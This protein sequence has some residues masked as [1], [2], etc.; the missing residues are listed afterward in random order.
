MDRDLQLR[1]SLL[2][3]D[4][5]LLSRPALQRLLIDIKERRIHVVVGRLRDL[6]ATNAHDGILEAARAQNAF[7]DGIMQA[8]YRGR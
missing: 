4:L 7:V 2:L 1:A 5:N 8:S 3:A 6:T